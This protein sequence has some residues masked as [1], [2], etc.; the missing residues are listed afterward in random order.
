MKLDS[1]LEHPVQ[2]F[3][4]RAAEGVQLIQVQK[5]HPALSP[6]ARCPSE[7]GAGDGA[8]GSLGRGWPL[9]KPFRSMAGLILAFSP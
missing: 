7:A 1:P 4:E 6:G 3:T 9:P 5:I 2:G 8:G